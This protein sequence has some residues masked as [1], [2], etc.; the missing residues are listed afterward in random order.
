VWDFFSF[1]L[2]HELVSNYKSILI[3]FRILEGPEKI[4]PIL[5]AS[6]SPIIYLSYVCFY[7]PFFITL[8]HFLNLLTQCIIRGRDVS[9][10]EIN[11]L[12]DLPGVEAVSHTE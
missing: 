12:N 3:V 6:P 5:A 9:Q 2:S 1:F 8:A 7:Q 10:V 11:R 4:M